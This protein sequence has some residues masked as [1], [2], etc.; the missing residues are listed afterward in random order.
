MRFAFSPDQLAMQTALRALLE[1]ECPASVVRA[2]WTSDTGHSPSLWRSLTEFGLVGMTAEAA[3]G[4][5]GLD[6]LDLV[7]LLEECG[8]A[9]VPAPVL[10]T[11]A[12]AAPLLRDAA[13]DALN[14][15]WQPALASGEAVVTVGLAGSDFVVAA[16]VADL[17]LLERSG[18]LHAVPAGALTRTAQRSVD[19]SRRLFTVQW[20]PSAETLVADGEVASRAIAAARDRGALAAAAQLLGLARQMIAMT[21]GHVAVRKQFGAAIG[22]FQAVKHHLANALVK[23]EFARPLVYRAAYSMARGDADRSL[24]VSMA[25]AQ[26]SDAAEVAARAA[27]QCHGAIGYSY[28]HD[29][30]LW[31]KRAWAL[32]AAW[33]SAAQH[34]ARVGEALF[35][36]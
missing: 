25:K 28:E 3:H 11:T 27:L 4:G 34:R 35:G 15:R 23:V 9:A 14:A 6:E 2:A 19:G 18:E 24:H 13:N 20:E 36:G 12:V 8:R 31:M 29:L 22:S 32:G 17:V 7:L 1:K 16:N 26:A 21:V 33:G 30:H 10:E 5:V